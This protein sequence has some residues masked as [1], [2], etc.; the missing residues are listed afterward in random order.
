LTP[1]IRRLRKK[2]VST[3]RY[4]TNPLVVQGGDEFWLAAVHDHLKAQAERVAA[5]TMVR[6]SSFGS[7]FYSCL[8]HD[9]S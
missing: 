1:L 6:W 4:E 2:G 9:R 3:L 5:A 7:W 8:H